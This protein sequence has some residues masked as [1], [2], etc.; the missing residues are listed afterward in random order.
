[1]FLSP[2]FIYFSSVS[3]GNSRHAGLDG[4]IMNLE[5]LVDVEAVLGMT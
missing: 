2:Y 1:M 4:C 5:H 3:K